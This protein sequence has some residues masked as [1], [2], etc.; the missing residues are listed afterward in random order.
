MQISRVTTLASAVTLVVAAASC[1][2]SHVAAAVPIDEIGAGPRAAVAPFGGPSPAL[3]QQPIATFST[4]EV[5]NIIVTLHRGQIELGRTALAHAKSP[6]VRAFGARVV[7]D[8][9]EGLTRAET[10]VARV[11]ALASDPTSNRIAREDALANKDLRQTAEAFDTDYMTSQI[12]AHAKLLGLIDQALLP[13]ALHAG[14]AEGA[15]A[16]ANEIRALRIAIV[17]HTVHALDVQHVLRGGPSVE[18]KL[19]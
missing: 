12:L 3:P 4:A 13:S 10:L 7:D 17:G 18:T 11:G 19:F 14:E 16:L 2:G 15:R 6:A 8:H 9:T 1:E 5:A